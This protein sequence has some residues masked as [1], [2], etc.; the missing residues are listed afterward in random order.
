VWKQ[1]NL[2][3][4]DGVGK[5]IAEKI[6]ELLSTGRLEFLDK[7]ESEV[8]PGLAELLQVPDLGPKRIALL[9]NEIGIT[10]LAELEA[11]A[12]EHKLKDLPGMGEKSE[13]KIL[14]GIE[15]LGRRSKRSVGRVLLLA[16]GCGL[17]EKA[18]GVGEVE[19]IQST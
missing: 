16:Q 4:V 13:A 1:G 10:N 3:E 5:A 15:A 9:W 8:P 14:A 19:T 17:P 7:L 6:D 2:T 18:Q 12:R 11:A